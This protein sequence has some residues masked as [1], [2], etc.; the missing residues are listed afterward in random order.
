MEF[1]ELHEDVL[2]TILIF[3]DLGWYKDSSMD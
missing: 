1:I 2:L 3:V